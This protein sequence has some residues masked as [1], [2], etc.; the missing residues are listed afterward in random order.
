M[1]NIFVSKNE[2]VAK[3]KEELARVKKESVD[4][5]MHLK[6]LNYQYY[7]DATIANNK[8]RNLDMS[9]YLERIISEYDASN[10]DE[11][12]RSAKAFQ[13]SFRNID[14][15]NYCKFFREML[16][17]LSLSL[18]RSSSDKNAFGEYVDKMIND[19]SD[20]EKINQKYADIKNEHLKLIQDNRKESRYC[21][22]WRCI[23]QAWNKIRKDT[24]EDK[25]VSRNVGCF[26]WQMTNYFILAIANYC[27]V[28]PKDLHF[29]DN[30]EVF[31]KINA[32]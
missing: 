28:E 29:K 31:I 23:L 19:L 6:R 20:V 5:I 26:N 1:W 7:E 32:D 4:R 27:G 22:N 18:M 3:L 30:G 13:E 12:L 25:F 2:Q 14:A 24:N 15:D 10:L 11:F 17:T 8:L 21:H 9:Y 16:E